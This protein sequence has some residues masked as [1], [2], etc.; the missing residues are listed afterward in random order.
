MKKKSNLVYS[1]SRDF[2][3]KEKILSYK[4]RVRKKLSKYKST[5]NFRDSLKK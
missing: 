4:Y 5:H 1:I 3:L 2:S